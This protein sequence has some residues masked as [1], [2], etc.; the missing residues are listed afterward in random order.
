MGADPN[1]KNSLANTALHKAFMTK[2]LRIIHLL[3]SSDAS[4]TCTN[5][6]NQT[7]TY[8]ADNE[9]ISD[10]GLTR[11]VTQYV[12]FGE[13]EKNFENDPRIIKESKVHEKRRQGIGKRKN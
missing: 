4:L 3:L 1:I 13:F 10:L 11:F 7:P 5:D 12:G 9:M 8:F 2:N 6:F